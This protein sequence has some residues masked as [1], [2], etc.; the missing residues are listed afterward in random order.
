MEI[1]KDIEGYEGLYQASTLGKIRSIYRY[2]KELKPSTTH[3]G[4]GRVNLAKNKHYK[5]RFVHNLI[6]ET[7]KGKIPDGMQVNHINE[8]KLDNRLENLN[9]MTPK[10]NTNWGT[11]IE[12]RS[13]KIA[14]PVIQFY[15]DGSVVKEWKSAEEVMKETGYCKS[16]ICLCCQGKQKTAYGFLWRYAV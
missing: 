5:K 15:L 1:W 16:C 4:Y 11:C 13:N 8:N 7:F 6:W 10:E 9:L 3:N 2:K 14:K 12:R